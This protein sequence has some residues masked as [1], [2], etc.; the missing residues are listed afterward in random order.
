MS[1]GHRA[2]LLECV[3]AGTLPNPEIRLHHRLEHSE[4]QQLQE[5]QAS[6]SI[7]FVPGRIVKVP[8][9]LSPLDELAGIA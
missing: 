7:V 8:L 4:A 1:S 2:V 9:K 5:F 3:R 6:S